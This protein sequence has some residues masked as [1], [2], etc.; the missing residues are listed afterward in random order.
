MRNDLALK[1]YLRHF[2]HMT[3]VKPPARA[4][5]SRRFCVAPMM[6]RAAGQESV[7]NSRDFDVAHEAHV[8]LLV[9]LFHPFFAA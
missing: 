1:R 3:E 2:R 8:V 7:L 4:P 6:E 9:V 5:L